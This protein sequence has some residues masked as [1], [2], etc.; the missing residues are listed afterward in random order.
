MLN[1]HREFEFTEK[2]FMWLKKQVMEQTGISLNDNKTDLVYG[3]LARRIRKLGLSN[4]DQYC[5]LLK[6]NTDNE[7]IEFVNS[8]TTNLTSFFREQHHFGKFKFAM[9][10]QCIN[11]RFVSI[12]IF[13]D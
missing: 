6:A 1:G 13:N 11:L 5:K 3:R 7:L 9:P 4:F 2:H 10:V 8:I 12:N